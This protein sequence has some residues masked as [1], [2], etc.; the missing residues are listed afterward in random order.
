MEVGG[1]QYKICHLT[2]GLHIDLVL[3]IECQDD[4]VLVTRGTRGL[5]IHLAEEQVQAKGLKSLILVYL[6]PV[7]ELIK[8]H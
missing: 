6:N 1:G 5:F 3:S 2:H 7:M 4:S 8:A